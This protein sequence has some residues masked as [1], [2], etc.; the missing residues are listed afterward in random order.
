MAEQLAAGRRPVQARSQATQS[1][2][3]TAAL[4]EFAAFGFDGASTRSIARR[5][6]VNHA[7]IAHHFG[8]KEG[9]YLAVFEAIADQVAGAMQP[10]AEA[11]RQSLAAAR[12]AGGDLH[13]TALAAL[14][15]ILCGFAAML[16]EEKTTAWARLIL[17][18]QQDPGPAFDILYDSFMGRLLDLMSE[19]VACLSDDALDD[20]DAAG[21]DEAR[22]CA[23]TLMG[24]VLVFR[25]ARAATLRHMG[26][27]SI[28]EQEIRSICTQLRLNL[29]ARFPPPK[30]G[31]SPEG[32]E[33]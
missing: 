1:A 32:N 8:G 26:W 16:G 27:R 3:V 29:A 2:I 15:K 23:L 13:G 12:Q 18:E 11:A 30:A 21:A 10:V 6:E 31:P 14:E 25:A 28:G 4:R 20:G 7:L 22:L 33:P 19:L 17:R 5:A 24:Q 9:F